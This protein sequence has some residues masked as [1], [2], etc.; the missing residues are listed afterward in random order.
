[1]CMWWALSVNEVKRIKPEKTIAC[2]L[3][4]LEPLAKRTGK[5]SKYKGTYLNPPLEFKI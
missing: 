5:R 4:Y 2:Y 1:M 3:R